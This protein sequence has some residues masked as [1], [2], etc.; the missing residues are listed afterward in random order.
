MTRGTHLR[1]PSIN[2]LDIGCGFG[3]HSIEFGKRG[4]DVVGFD[5]SAAMIA[6][7]NRRLSLEER[8]QETQQIQGRVTFVQADAAG[9][10]TQAD[11]SARFHAAVCLMTTLG[12]I[13]SKRD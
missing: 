12:Q 4:F 11:T 1:P 8:Q 13:G 9:F 10:L 6:D 2:L 3:R 7:A 5:P